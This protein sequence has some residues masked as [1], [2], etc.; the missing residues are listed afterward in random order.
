MNDHNKHPDDHSHHQNDHN[1]HHQNWNLRLRKVDLEDR[2]VYECQATTHP[3]Q[4]TFV[5]LKVVGEYNISQAMSKVC[6]IHKMCRFPLCLIILFF[7]SPSPRLWGQKTRCPFSPI[8]I[9]IANIKNN[10]R[11]ILVKVIIVNNH[12]R[13][14][15]KK[16]DKNND[17]EITMNFVQGV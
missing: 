4:S 5:T 3:P 14:P 12:M 7:Q 9:E 16:K 8:K 6:L 2:G 11:L 1:N 13:W 15:T 10:V 17:D